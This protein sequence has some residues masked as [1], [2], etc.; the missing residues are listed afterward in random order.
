MAEFNSKDEIKRQQLKNHFLKRVIVR[1]DYTS[2]VNLQN[3]LNHIVAFLNPPDNYFRS[4]NQMQIAINSQEL[5]G[6]LDSKSTA[7]DRPLVYRFSDCIIEPIQDVTLDFAR[8]YLC[9]EI[10]C[11]QDYTVIDKYLEMM[12]ALMDVILQC[13][14]FVQLT[15]IGI[16]KIDGVD[17]INPNDANQVFEYFSQQL[18]WGKRDRMVMRQYTDYMTCHDIPAY[19]IYHRIVRVLEDSPDLRFTLDIDCYKDSS[20]LEAR[21]KADVI[22]AWL[23]AMNAK[24][25]DLFKMGIKLE[26]FNKNI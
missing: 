5:G 21:P 25:F 14:C 20:F 6:T 17:A 15:R 2:I 24:M 8:N 19:V 3:V 11:N 1:F 22:K 18:S 13:E 12:T 26:F 9:L 10:R 7:Q 23:N 16:R 4:L